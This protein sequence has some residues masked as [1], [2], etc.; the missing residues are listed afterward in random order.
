LV[1]P[2]FSGKE[3]L[4]NARFAGWMHDLKLITAD[5]MFM[6]VTWILKLVFDDKLNIKI[7]KSRISLS[8]DRRSFAV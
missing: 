5:R 4:S 3:L 7:R 2:S 1:S 6:A 8:I